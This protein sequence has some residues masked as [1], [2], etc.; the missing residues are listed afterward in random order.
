MDYAWIS[1]MERAKLLFCISLS[2]QSEYSALSFAFSLLSSIGV[3]TETLPKVIIH[4]FGQNFIFCDEHLR[5]IPAKSRNLSMLTQA[6]CVYIESMEHSRWKSKIY[7]QYSLMWPACWFEIWFH[8]L[9]IISK[10][11]FQK[12][13]SVIKFTSKTA[14]TFNCL[15]HT[16]YPTWVFHFFGFAVLTSSYK[17][18]LCQKWVIITVYQRKFSLIFLIY[19]TLINREFSKNLQSRS[20]ICNIS[21]NA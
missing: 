21:A 3:S 20:P 12:W 7:I 8:S 4:R 6:V 16:N 10:W 19:L 17:A 11:P 13:R 5:V 15:D 18:I 2:M 14:R 1:C 9:Y